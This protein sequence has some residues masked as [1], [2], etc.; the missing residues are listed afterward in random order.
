MSPGEEMGGI[1]GG[2]LDLER[3][4]VRQF[5][6]ETE[7]C[8]WGGDI[9]VLLK[10]VVLSSKSKYSTGEYLFGFPLKL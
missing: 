7:T 4:R 3:G 10:T 9:G 8:G 1:W 2:Q 6:P 5:V